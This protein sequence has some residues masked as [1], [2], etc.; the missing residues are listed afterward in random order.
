M[1]GRRLGWVWGIMLDLGIVLVDVGLHGQICD[2]C[3]EH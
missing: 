1:R 3:V 2:E